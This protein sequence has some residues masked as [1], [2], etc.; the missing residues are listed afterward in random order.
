[1]S[2]S[3][4]FTSALRLIRPRSRRRPAGLLLE[5][6]EPRNLLS[7]FHLDFVATSNG[8]PSPVAPGYV[9]VPLTPYSPSLGYGWDNLAGLSATD[10]GT[11]D[12]LTHD[13]Q[14]GP[15]GTF[16][17]DLPNGTYDVTPTLG[18]AA[19]AHP[20]MAVWL[21]GSPQATGLDAAAGQFLRPTY[22]VNVTAGQLQLRLTGAGAGFAL[23]AL[24]VDPVQSITIDQAWLAARGA[25]PY[26]LDQPHT[27]YTLTT[28]VTTPATAFVVA[29]AHV[30][31][32]LG[33]HQVVYGDAPPP[34]L[35]NGGFEQGSGRDVPGW[36]LSG[37]PDAALAPNTNYLFGSQV[38]RL[39]SFSTPQRIT[40]ADIDIPTAGH[41]Y[42][43]SITPVEREWPV[44]SVTLSVIDTVTGAVL[45]RNSSPDPSRGFS[46][47]ARFIPTTTHAVRLQID[48]VPPTGQTA[49][50]DLDGATLLAADDYG[51]L[52]SGQWEGDLPGAVNLPTAV[53][54]AYRDAADFTLKNGTVEQGRGQ[55]HASD[56]LYFEQLPGGLDVV[57]V[58][59]V[60]GGIDTVS[61]DA[62]Y[63]SGGVTIRDSIFEE[64][65]TNITNRLRD[66]A[67]VQLGRV[68]G[69]ILVSGNQL[70]GSPQIG[71]LL[72]HDDPGYR[73]VVTGNDISQNAVVTNA[74]G[75][76]VA[77]E[78]HFEI[79]D[80]TIVPVNGRGISLDGF[81]HTPIIDGS[82]HDNYVLVRE[83]PERE[84]PVTSAR[85]L[86]LRNNV[87]GMGPQRDIH[88]YNNTFIAE[89]GTGLAQQA[90]GV[91]IS[92]VNPKGAMNDANILLED[93]T[94]GA[95]VTTADAGYQAQALLV[96]G[97]DPGINLKVVGNTLESNDVSLA[98][99]GS[100][101][102]DI[103]DVL[104][105]SNTLRKL[106]GPERPYTGTLAGFWVHQIHRVTIL[107]MQTDGGATTAITWAGSG[108]K[109]I[110]VGSLGVKVVDGGGNPQAGADVEVLDPDGQTVFTGTT[111]A[112]GEVQGTE[113]VTTVYRQLDAS[114]SVIST[115]SRG[116]FRITASLGSRTA[117]LL[118]DLVSDWT[119]SLVLPATAS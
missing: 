32:D 54:D 12:P 62:N 87:D 105:L 57:G 52:A 99:G 33:G 102:G 21:Q 118:V 84:Y 74:Y 93:N 30:S 85:A 79:A 16:L 20:G 4:L 27:A 65:V 19:A 6:L 89:T 46:A 25:G 70:L 60:A 13:F 42:T 56:P 80:N 50:L 92:Y 15:D 29:A 116:P 47:V 67:T 53:R 39:T 69:P 14:S 31:L 94:I 28:D 112:G 104:F 111:D 76:L 35:V 109:D 115:E 55:G 17:I 117:G 34:A 71:I 64:H 110:S 81:S 108:T 95:I 23:D 86:R 83:R 37:A 11:S 2:F 119:V 78:Q 36:D 66:Y 103:Y 18:D 106:S 59:T 24:D 91:R 58:H 98:L 43:A 82:I 40:S 5:E 101:G 113:V 114:P 22:R 38:L 88:I 77:G 107:D 97:V 3:S 45:A 63:V 51:V 96:D 8:L 41:A 49:T 9:G 48:V 26:V 7:A 100:D 75:I 68:V 90:Y 61:L 73:T 72:S 10:R 1:M 44:A